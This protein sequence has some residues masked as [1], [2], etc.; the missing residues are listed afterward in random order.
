VPGLDDALGHARVVDPDPDADE[1]ADDDEAEKEA[2]DCSSVH[3]VPS[4]L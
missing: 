3:L 2:D 1:D 4:P